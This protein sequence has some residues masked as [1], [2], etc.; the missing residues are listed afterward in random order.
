MP[1]YAFP[2][3]L[4][5]ALRAGDVHLFVGSGVSCSAGL[6]SWD[7]LIAEMKA[8]ILRENGTFPR[9][10]LQSYID[11]ASHLDIADLFRNTVQTHRYIQFL[12]G[13]FR[14]RAAL[15]QLH[16]ALSLIPTRT[17]FTTNY[18]KL[19]EQMVRWRKGEEPSVII[20]PQQLGYIGESELKII[21]IHGDIDHPD[22]IVLTQQDYAAYALRHH[23]FETELHRSINNKTMLFV[24]FGLRDHNFDRVWNDARLLFDSGKRQAYALMS[25]TNAV[26]RG[27]W[28]AR[29]LRILPVRDHNALPSVLRGLAGVI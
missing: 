26:M 4:I 20:Y 23:A 9:T 28:E 27:V 16:R 25:D 10:D 8:T 15:S 18:D 12:R 11:T 29:G 2:G 7:D 22:S 24:G 14:R 6:P 3:D 19:L 1:P 5:D 21:K 13:K 17:I